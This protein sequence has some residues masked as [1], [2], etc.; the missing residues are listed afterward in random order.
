MSGNALN[1]VVTNAVANGARTI[2][3]SRITANGQ[4]DCIVVDDDPDMLEL[5]ASVLSRIG[6]KSAGVTSAGALSRALS[7]THP[8]IV[9][10]DIGLGR[11]DAV[12]GIRLLGAHRFRGAVQLISGKEPALLSEVRA[13]GE[14][15]GLNMLTPLR[16]PFESDHLITALQGGRLSGQTPAL[17]E[18]NNRDAAEA[19]GTPV[20][21]SLATA[22]EHRWLDVLYQPKIDLSGSR[23][24]GAEGL[25]RVRH[26]THGQL[27]PAAFLPGASSEDLQQLT[28]FVVMKAFRDWEVLDRAG[29]NVRLS[30]NAPVAALAGPRLTQLIREGRPTAEDWPGLIIEITESD[31]IK[32]INLTAEVALQLRIY[33][34]ELAIDDFGT[35]YSSFARLKQFAFCE[36]KLDRSYVQNCATDPI[37]SCICQGVINLAHAAQAVAVAEGVESADERE[38]LL[39]MGCDLAQGYLFGRPMSVG[40]VIEMNAGLW[41][42]PPSD[43]AS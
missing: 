3:F 32:D 22:I 14:R 6:V 38:V 33:N 11:W 4:H 42:D 2:P 24:V 27:T 37:N 29:C 40:K 8:A 30:V 25:A 34:V 12:D 18:G 41:L 21:V 26:P 31:A 16:K 13:L 36:L 19:I 23:I 1:H 20:S 5:I 9:F 43:R 10:L 39:A 28:E 17:A 15:H 7:M 35:G